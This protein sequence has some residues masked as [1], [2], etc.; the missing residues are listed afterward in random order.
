MVIK[1]VRLSKQAKDQ[2]SRLKPKQELEIGI[3][4]VDGL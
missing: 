2:L 3:L 4:F 1:Q